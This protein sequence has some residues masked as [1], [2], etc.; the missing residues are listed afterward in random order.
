MPK[1]RLWKLSH[2]GQEL[3]DECQPR[4]SGRRPG[5]SLRSASQRDGSCRMING[6]VALAR[7]LRAPGERPG[8]AR[9]C[10]EVQAG[11]EEL[12]R[13]EPDLQRDVHRGPREERNSNCDK[14]H[15]VQRSLHIPGELDFVRRGCARSKRAKRIEDG[16]TG[17]PW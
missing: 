5:K 6:G 12:R 8:K 2:L 15:Q 17:P 9:T 13:D 14:R 10:P 4:R 11:N 7:R 16:P 3:K 1:Q